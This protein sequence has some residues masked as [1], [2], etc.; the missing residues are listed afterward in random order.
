[1]EMLM[2]AAM[3]RRVQEAGIVAVLVLHETE[4]VRPTI[5]ALLAGGIEAVELTLRTPVAL[6]AVRIIHEEYSQM[7][8]GVGT[9]LTAQ[10]AV[11]AQQAGADFGV[12]PGLNRKV[13][14]TA[15]RIGLPY[16]PGIATPSD[17]ESALEYDCRLLKFF[18]AE[19]IGGIE[20]LKSMNAPYNHLGLSY[21]PLGGINERNLA[22]YAKESIIAG[23]GGSWIA[24]ASLISEGRWNAI[25]DNAKT[26][27]DMFYKERS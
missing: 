15:K 24:S 21:I 18:P 14:D 3:Q 5:E 7:L 4:Q 23:I 10:Q 12:A 22:S 16:A 2:N 11:A 9:I 8:C 25:T 13:M 20:Y 19:T 6:D 17:I 26:A 1:M 27:V